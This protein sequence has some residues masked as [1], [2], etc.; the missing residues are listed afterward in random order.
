M[1]GA[2]LS[3]WIKLGGVGV[4]VVD[5]GEPKLPLGA[6]W[7][8]SVDDLPQDERFDAMILAVKP[9]LIDVA[10]PPAARFV[11][12]GRGISGSTPTMRLAIRTAH[13]D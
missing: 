13:S 1:G 12:S 6:K 10:I 5:P 11:S 3:R 7:V 4:T 2:L 8:K 9:Q